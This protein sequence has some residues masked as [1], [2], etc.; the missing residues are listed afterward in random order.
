MFTFHEK[1]RFLD[2]RKVK[3][4][5]KVKSKMTISGLEDKNMRAQDRAIYFLTT[6]MLQGHIQ[7]GGG[8]E[9]LHHQDLLREKKK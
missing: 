6:L 4:N 9:T 5:I 8:S 3:K 1:I 2:V 7:R